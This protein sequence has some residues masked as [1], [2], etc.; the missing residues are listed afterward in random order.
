MVDLEDGLISQTITKLWIRTT[1]SLFGKPLNKYMIK[2]L[3]IEMLELCHSPLNAIPCLVISKLVQTTK[4]P[5][6]QPSSSLSHSLMSQIPVSLL[7]QPL[8]GLCH[9]TLLLLSTLNAFILRCKMKPITRFIS[10]LKPESRT[11]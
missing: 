5:K 8:L 10:L 7:G 4:M 2:D 11:P 9:P 1:W 3:F 6:I